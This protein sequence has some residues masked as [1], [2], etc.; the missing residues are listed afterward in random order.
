MQLLRSEETRLKELSDL[1]CT[2]QSFSA[3]V[4]RLANSPLF[5]FRTE[6]KGILQAIALL[7]AERIKAVAF[8][9][10]MQT[11]LEEPLKIPVLRNCWRHNLACAIIAE[12]LGHVSLMEEDFAY[13]AGLLHDIGR[14]ALMVAEPVRYAR[15]VIE[16]E[17]SPF[18]ILERE[19]E[20]FDIDHCEAG[21]WLVENWKLPP[22]FGMVAAHHHLEF[23]QRSF[24]IIALVHASCRLSD[25]IGYLAVKPLTVPGIDQ[26]LA[27]LPERERALFHPHLDRLTVDIDLKIKSLE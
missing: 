14:L 11:Y 24:D 23:R 8:T 17:E 2:D 20:W 10:G 18:N 4:L 13:T 5:G 15:L 22:V 16:A 7:G 1:I 27:G 21:R 26:V 19:R 12:K 25:A 6:I 3:E 9:V